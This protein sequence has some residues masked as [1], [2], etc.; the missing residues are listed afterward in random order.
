MNY[1][2]DPAKTKANVR[3]HSVEFA[4]AI[5]VFD[6]P[7]AVTIEIRIQKGNSGF[8]QLVWIS[9][10]ASLWSPIPIGV[11]DARLISARKAT[12]KEVRIYE[13]RI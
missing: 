2:W 3:K 13:K 6:D 11:I 4:D 5:A 8:Y 10:V 9:L 12:K 7:E 1:Q